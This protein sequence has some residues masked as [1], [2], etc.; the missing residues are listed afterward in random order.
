MS[1]FFDRQLKRIAAKAVLGLVAGLSFTVGLGF[2][3]AAAWI[4]LADRYDSLAAAL[5]LGFAY[6]ALSATNLAILA[7]S[8]RRPPR[9]HMPPPGSDPLSLIEAFFSGFDAARRRNAD[10]R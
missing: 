3:T 7:I 5:I 2:L 8:R 6:I 10:R 9:E 4:V 1:G